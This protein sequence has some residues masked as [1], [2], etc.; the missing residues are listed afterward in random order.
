MER[1]SVREPGQ[2]CPRCIGLRS[3]D[4]CWDVVCANLC[5]V[6]GSASQTVLPPTAPTVGFVLPAPD[7]STGQ[8]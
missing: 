8:V 6:W 1:E 7:A 2:P 4:R 3:A 5:Q